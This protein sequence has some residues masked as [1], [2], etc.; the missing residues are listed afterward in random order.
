M[1]SIQ[2]YWYDVG[3]FLHHKCIAYSVIDTISLF[4]PDYNSSVMFVSH[5]FNIQ[6]WYRI[7]NIV[8]YTCVIQT[9]TERLPSG[10]K[11]DIVSLTLYIRYHISYLMVTVLYTF[12]SHMYN[13]QCYW[14]DILYLPDGNR[15]VYVCITHV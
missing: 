12:V 9:L 8:Y 10:R 2:C 6:W 1:Y 15:S 13:I 14:Y 7:N 4:L 11:S 3:Y 5:M